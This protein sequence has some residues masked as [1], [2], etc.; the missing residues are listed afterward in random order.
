MTAVAAQPKVTTTTALDLALEY[1]ASAVTSMLKDRAK[2]A[3]SLNGVAQDA[4][5]IY[6]TW[7]SDSILDAS[8][9]ESFTLT[10]SDQVMPDKGS[11]AV[12]G[13]I[14]YG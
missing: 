4:Q 9:I 5:T 6:A 13:T 11:M 12:L 10:M 7:V 3:Y 1:I 8:G 2:P 14:S